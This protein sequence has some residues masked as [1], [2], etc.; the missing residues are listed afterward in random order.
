MA[1]KEITAPAPA[2]PKQIIARSVQEEPTSLQSGPGGGNAFVFWMASIADIFSPW[3]TNV[4]ERDKQ[5][6]DWWHTESV[7]A[8]AIYTVT[9]ANAG[10]KWELEGPEETTK[11]VQEILQM[12]DMG[13]G[14]RHFTNKISIDL[15]SQDNGAF[16]EIIRLT[17]SPSAPIIG[18]SHLESYRCQRTGDLEIPVVYEDRRGQRHKM[19]Y[20]SVVVLEEFPS[21]IEEMHSVQYCAV[22]RILRMAQIMRDIAIFRG[23]KVGGRFTE[24]IHIIGGVKQSDIDDIR[25]RMEEQGDNQG[26]ARY[27]QPLILAALDPQSSPSSTTINMKAL[28]DAFS[29]DD[30]LR[31][32]ISI[33]AMGFGRD[34]QDFAPLPRGGL[35][36][37]AQSGTLHLKSSGKGPATFRELITHAMNAYVMPQ[38]VTFKFDVQDIEAELKEAQVKK[39]RA[40]ARAIR[41][42]D[43]EIGPVLARQIANDEGDLDVRYLELM[44]ED[45]LTPDMMVEQGEKPKPASAVTVDEEEAR[46]EGGPRFPFEIFRRK[47]N[48]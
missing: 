3:G 12:A 22:T 33:I 37:G 2:P 26:L 35:G 38:T 41:I 5:L 32:Y 44:E 42:R 1:D 20:Y 48:K 36:S 24:A 14:W 9:S 29:L 15:Y 7:L 27:L 11:Q 13:K 10:F 34:Y 17:N 6:R 8:S 47:S 16:I 46:K 43:G 25:A 18:I 31:W 4:K 40:E 39:E 28:P 19:P 21:P 45:D 23:E 30:E